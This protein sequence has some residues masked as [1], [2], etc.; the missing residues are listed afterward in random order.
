MP[1]RIKKWKAAAAAFHELVGRQKSWRPSRHCQCKGRR[2]ICAVALRSPTNCHVSASL[3][4][5]GREIA[6]LRHSWHIQMRLARPARAVEF[7]LRLMGAWGGAAPWAGPRPARA[8]RTARDLDFSGP[9][10]RGRQDRGPQ[11]RAQGT[12]ERGRQER[13]A[14]RLDRTRQRSDRYMRL[15]EQGRQDRRSQRRGP[16]AR[17]EGERQGRR[18]RRRGRGRRSEVGKSASPRP[19]P[20]TPPARKHEK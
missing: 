19:A 8:R 1:R 3:R 2:P 17:P 16:A 11:W 14:P 10:E 4:L 5:E 6:C 12:G 7:C 13:V 20:A 15:H 18:S 9:S